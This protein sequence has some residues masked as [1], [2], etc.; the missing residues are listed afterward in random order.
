MKPL[1]NQIPYHSSI[2]R[3]ARR[4]EKKN[5]LFKWLKIKPWITEARAVSDIKRQSMETTLPRGPFLSWPG[6]QAHLLSVT[7]E[8]HLSMLTAQFHWP[9]R[10]RHKESKSYFLQ[11]T[12]SHHL[13]TCIVQGFRIQV[14][15]LYW[16]ITR[17]VCESDGKNA[18]M[19][20]ELLQQYM[21]KVFTQCSKSQASNLTKSKCPLRIFVFHSVKPYLS[22]QKVNNRAVSQLFNTLAKSIAIPLIFMMGWLHIMD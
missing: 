17:S 10:Q 4:E 21:S 1:H 2:P 22:N 3:N 9:F 20:W 18:S 7:T 6:L 11:E 8:T 13:V 19:S 16:I 15:S 5:I 12:T 14:N